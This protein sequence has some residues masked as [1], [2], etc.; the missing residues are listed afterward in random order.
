MFLR[1][2]LL[3]LLIII[4]IMHVFFPIYQLGA[5]G[6]APQHQI[7]GWVWETIWV[8]TATEMAPTHIL[9][10]KLFASFSPYTMSCSKL[11]PTAPG[12]RKPGQRNIDKDTFLNVV[13]ELLLLSGERHRLAITKHLEIVNHVILIL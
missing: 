4:I 2:I 9:N 12:G 6:N 11:A 13:E 8:K 10:S 3:K 1:V 5:S 7:L